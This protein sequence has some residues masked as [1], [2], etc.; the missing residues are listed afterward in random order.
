MMGSGTLARPRR[1][2]GRRLSWAAALLL[3]PLSTAAPSATTSESAASAD[4]EAPPGSLSEY[5]VKGA[6]LYKFVAY[7]TWPPS[8]FEDAGDPIVLALLGGHPHA[9]D[10]EEVLRGKSVGDRPLAVRHVASLEEC[11]GA[12]VVYSMGENAALEERLIGR[13]RGEPSLLLSDTE[14]FA[15]RGGTINFF[16]LDGKLRFAVNKGRA[17]GSRLK[18]SSELLKLARIVGGDG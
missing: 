9:R 6:F 17:A 2:S 3:F 15:E 16:L 18:I 14:D 7:T 10:V 13:L 12:H 5:R 1:R 4:P 11:A 8:A